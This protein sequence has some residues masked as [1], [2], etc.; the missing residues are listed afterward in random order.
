MS[1]DFRHYLWVAIHKGDLDVFN[2]VISKMKKEGMLEQLNIRDMQ[3]VLEYWNR[4]GS[5]DY[6]KE[7]TYKNDVYSAVKSL[8]DNGVSVRNTNIISYCMCECKFVSIKLLDLLYQNEADINKDYIVQT[9]LMYACQGEHASLGAIQF[10]LDKNADVDAVGFGGKNALMY[11]CQKFP[12]H[13]NWQYD[14]TQTNYARVARRLI[15]RTS[16]LNAVNKYGETATS[17][18][19]ER[20]KGNSPDVV[21]KCNWL[22]NEISREQNR[23][24]GISK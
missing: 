20:A 17:I 7:E 9:G 23:R 21:E 11:F 22:I 13:E 10:F 4:D 1:F 8:I 16:D 18:L 3:W 14:E 15:S 6:D 19:K 12:F 2:G 5:H 24:D